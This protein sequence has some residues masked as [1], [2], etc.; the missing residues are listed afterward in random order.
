M[1]STITRL[2]SLLAFLFLPHV[3]HSQEK[4]APPATAEKT[5]PAAAPPAAEFKLPGVTIDRQKKEVRIDAIACLETG[6]LEFAV[7]KPGTFE[8]EAL[9][10]TTARPELIHAALLLCGLKASPQTHAIPEIWWNEVAKKPESRVHIH[11]EWEEDSKKKRFSLHDLMQ[12]RKEEEAVP[13]QPKVQIPEPQDSWI[14]CGS[15]IHG[16]EDGGKKVYAANIS[17]VV[18]G[19]WPDPTALIQYGIP[20]ENPYGDPGSGLEINEKNVPKTGTQVQMIFSY[21]AP[22]AEAKAPPT[23][24]A[25]PP[26]PKK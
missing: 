6:I 17:G 15:F 10:T 12:N 3:A 18:V 22:E 26:Q 14:F 20:N 19:I 5:P 2:T 16:P 21:K 7:C 13:E 24:G 25:P 4:P 1:S 11:V 8:H 23:E 9:F